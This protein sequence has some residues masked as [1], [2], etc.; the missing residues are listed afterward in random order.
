M[1]AIYHYNEYNHHQQT[2]HLVPLDIHI[3]DP[4]KYPI[5]M[6]SQDQNKLRISNCTANMI[7]TKC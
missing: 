4:E 2:S 1:K 6:K 5:T 3:P 7:P